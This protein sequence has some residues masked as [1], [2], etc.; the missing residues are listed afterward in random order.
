MLSSDFFLVFSFQEERKIL[1][2]LNVSCVKSV[3][4]FRALMIG[5]VESIPAF[6]RL[7]VCWI[8]LER[9]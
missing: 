8:T 6:V 9:C 5:T 4:R 1:L 2:F 7:L 3:N